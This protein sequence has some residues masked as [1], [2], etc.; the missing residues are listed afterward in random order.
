METFRR[1]P[2][3]RILCGLVMGR[4]RSRPGA[5]AGVGKDTLAKFLRTLDLILPVSGSSLAFK[6][7]GCSY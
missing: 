4:E 2:L 6:Q 7:N 1:L 5:G 3:S